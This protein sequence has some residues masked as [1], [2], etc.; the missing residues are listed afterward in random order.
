MPSLR[1]LL[2]VSAFIGFLFITMAIIG[3][4]LQANRRL[5][6]EQIYLLKQL[7]DKK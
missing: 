2:A 3:I 5:A 1:T 6:E 7:A 4:L